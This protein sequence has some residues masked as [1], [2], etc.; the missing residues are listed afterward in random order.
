[1]CV[2]TEQLVFCYRS[3]TH[4]TVLEDSALEIEPVTALIQCSHCRY[5]GPPKYWEGALAGT[6]FLLCNVPDAV[7]RRWLRKGTNVKSNRS[8]SLNRNQRQRL[9]N[10]S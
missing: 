4:D 8:S 10:S 5:Q 1:M 3:I 9:F 7:K 6:P 2:A